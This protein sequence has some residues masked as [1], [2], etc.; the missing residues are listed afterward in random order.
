MGAEHA[1]FV[2][3]IRHATAVTGA[4]VAT[5]NALQVVSE[6]WELELVTID[7]RRALTYLGEITGDDVSHGLTDEIFSQFCIG[8]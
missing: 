7:V 2:T 3:N 4:K 8:K 6:G 5:E 1:Q